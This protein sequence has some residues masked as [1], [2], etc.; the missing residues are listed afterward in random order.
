MTEQS[1]IK[2]HPLSAT[3]MTTVTSSPSTAFYCEHKN[4]LSCTLL[5]LRMC[6]PLILDQGPPIVRKDN[7]F[8]WGLLPL[9]WGWGP[10]GNQRRGE[11]T[12]ETLP[13]HATQH[14]LTITA[15]PNTNSSQST[16]YWQLSIFLKSNKTTTTVEQSNKAMLYI[17]QIRFEQIYPISF[18]VLINDR[19]QKTTKQREI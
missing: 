18:L 5:W 14:R 17:M 15:E 9:V 13:S 1:K 2:T 7:P 10:S 8:P 12:R 11:G 16:F 19:Q 6:F 3:I 4:S